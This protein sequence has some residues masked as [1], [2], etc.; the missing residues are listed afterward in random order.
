[1]NVDVLVVVGLVVALALCAAL[2][3]RPMPKKRALVYGRAAVTFEVAELLV[4]AVAIVYSARAREY[5]FGAVLLVALLTHIVQISRCERQASA[6]PINTIAMIGYMALVAVAFAKR[7]RW[8][9]M[10][11]ICGAAIHLYMFVVQRPFISKVCWRHGALVSVDNEMVPKN[12]RKG[13]RD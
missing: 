10:L 5:A 9:A 6:G 4:I 13:L 1:M 11:M 2:G 12:I 8:F 7:Q 3:P